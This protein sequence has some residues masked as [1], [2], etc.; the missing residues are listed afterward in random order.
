MAKK[1]QGDYFV[2][3]NGQNRGADR[4]HYGGCEYFKDVQNARKYALGRLPAVVAKGTPVTPE[5]ET[6]LRDKEMPYL[7]VGEIEQGLYFM[8]EFEGTS[9]SYVTQRSSVDD[10]ENVVEKISRVKDV[11]RTFAG[12][13][14]RVG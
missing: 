12:I 7:V 5:D 11:G 1:N 14:L 9:K 8:G 13:E 6:L 4:M 2:L 10:L 3:Y